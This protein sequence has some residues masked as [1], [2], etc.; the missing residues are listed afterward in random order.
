MEITVTRKETVTVDRLR[1]QC[2]VRYW[3]DATV[4]GVVDEDGTLIPCRVGDYWCPTIILETGQIMEWP[5]GTI[6]DIYYKVCDD[7]FYY[8][9]APSGEVVS[10]RKGYVPSMLCPSKNGFGDYVIM[11]VGPDGVIEGW[12][13]SPSDFEQYE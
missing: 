10:R 9:L 3:E 1:A 12:K 6:A 2:G 7:G 13:A 8:L 11:S 5:E 4:N